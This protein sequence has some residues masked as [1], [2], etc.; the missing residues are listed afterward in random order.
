MQSVNANERKDAEIKDLKAQL[1]EVRAAQQLQSKCAQDLLK[2]I[3]EEGERDACRMH[4]ALRTANVKLLC[5]RAEALL[6]DRPHV[7]P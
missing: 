7:S 5:T 6:V 3:T 4:E 2:A 1:L